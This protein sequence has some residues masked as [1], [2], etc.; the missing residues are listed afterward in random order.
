MRT[1]T[2]LLTA[3]LGAASIATAMAQTVYSV[4]AVGY[5]KIGPIPNAQFFL[6]A[7][8]LNI[9]TGNTLAAVFPDAPANTVI[10]QLIGGN[11]VQYTK[12][13]TGWTGSGA[14]TAVL[15]P[16]TG[17]F[18]E[19]KTGADLSL[20][21]VGEVVQGTVSTSYPAGY[22]LL[23]SKI[24]QEGKVETDLKL[25]AANGDVVYLLVSG[26]YVQSTRRATTWTPSEPTIGVGNGF[27]LNAKAAGTWTRTFNVNQ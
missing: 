11:F 2:L 9:T 17:F 23:G 3:V 5:V 7:N 16:G 8:P 22:S 25:G 21:F 12:R 10:W 6:A 13:A 19:N 20:T 18:I 1:K 26:Q 14:S 24:P 27:F 15:D 4:N